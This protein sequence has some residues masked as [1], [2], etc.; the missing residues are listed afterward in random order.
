MRDA[1]SRLESSC[2]KVARERE[3]NK[4][5]RV[6]LGAVGWPSLRSSDS[7]ESGCC[8]TG[9]GVVADDVLAFDFE[10]VSIVE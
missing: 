9:F 3:G 7:M 2:D 6:A 4:A 1:E 8:W 5:G 10:G